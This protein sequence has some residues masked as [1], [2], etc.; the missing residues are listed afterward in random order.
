MIFAVWEIRTHLLDFFY[1]LQLL[2]VLAKAVLSYA[3]VTAAVLCLILSIPI[4]VLYMV[5]IFDRKNKQA[6]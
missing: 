1:S 2:P 5:K 6:S 4:V 3:S